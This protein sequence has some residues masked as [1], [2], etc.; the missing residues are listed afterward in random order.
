MHGTSEGD[1]PVKRIAGYLDRFGRERDLSLPPMGADGL[2]HV[3]RGSAVVSVHV[4]AE[5]GILLVLS[6]VLDAAPAG[7]EALLRKLLEL[8]FTATGDAAF[9][10]HPQSGAVYLRILRGLEGL[11]YA[12]FEDMLHTIAT[13][14]DEWDD[15]LRALA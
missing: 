3:Q 9:A 14:A 1:D 8:S 10:L 5:K 13:V 7:N 11:D 2:G 15:K 6:K 12:E 4:L